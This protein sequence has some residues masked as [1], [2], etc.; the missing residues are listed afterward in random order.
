MK[1]KHF[2]NIS[3][4]VSFIFAILSCSKQPTSLL[5]HNWDT[6]IKRNF[7]GNSFWGNRLQ[8]WQMNNGRIECSN[9][10]DPWRTVHILTHEINNSRKSFQMEL[11][12]GLLHNEKPENDAFAGLLL[13]AGS[14]DLDYRGRCLIF[15]RPS[16]NGGVLAGING[17]GE[18]VILD[19]ENDLEIIAQESPPKSG[20]SIEKEKGYH[21]LVEAVSI[22]DYFQITAKE[23]NSGQQVSGKIPAENLS[24]NIGLVAHKGNLAQMGSFWFRDLKFG[25]E[26]IDHFPGRSLGPII[27]TQHT[28]SRQ[29]LKMAVQLM[30]IADQDPGELIFEYRTDEDNVW[31]T[32]SLFKI[33]RDGYVATIKIDRWNDTK[34]YEYRVVYN[35][36]GNNGKPEVSRYKGTIRKNPIHK[37]EFIIAAFTGNNNTSWQS[38]AFDRTR[39]FFPHEDLTDRVAMHQPDFLFYSGD[40]LYEGSPSYPDKSGGRTSMLDYLYK[41]YL[42]CWAHR[43]LTRNIPSVSIPDDHDVFHGNLWG[44]GG[45]IPASEPENGIYPEHYRGG[46]EGHW[47]QDQGGYKMGADFVNM[48][49]KTQTSNL[50]DPVDPGPVLNDIGVYFTD[51]NYGGVSMAVLED[52]KFKSAPSTILTEDEIINGFSQIPDYDAAK[53]DRKEASLLGERQLRFINDW[54]HDWEDT[55]IKV[56]LTQTIFANVSTYPDSFKTDAGTPRLQPLEQGVIPKDYSVAKDMDS[57][58]WPQTGRN[59]ALESLRKGYTFMI[60]GDQHLGSVV[61]HGIDDWEDAGISFC[62]PSV[63]NVWPRRWF[64]PN[65]GLNHQEGRPGYTGQYFDGF[66]NR[67]TVHAA[68]NPYISNVYPHELHDRAPGYGIIKIRKKEQKITVECWPRHVDPSQPNAEQYPDW[69]LTFD[70]QDNYGRKAIAWLPTI[71]TKGLENPPVIQVK[72]ETSGEIIY[73]IRAKSKTFDAKVFSPGKYTISLGEPGSENWKSIENIQSINE[74][75]SRSVSIDF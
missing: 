17:K 40:Q 50:P 53:S 1:R 54:V 59:K 62:V 32:S 12:F 7:L 24:G 56:S 4:L 73:T 5:I 58:G 37:D 63:A 74:K 43:E 22:D 8:D 31:T 25:G 41:W 38:D 19:M 2:L 14:L 30:P 71:E 36:T 15:N 60:A 21:I 51:I 45:K 35:Y 34:D 48:V 27:S 18:L 10:K 57:N 20:F 42:W 64:P 66:G 52:R 29:V 3:I 39:L 28:L 65:P 6:S 49:E 70:L 26:K 23:T 75:G 33:D 55:W 46:F 68:S 47:E 44:A 13:G 69:P 61:H 11:N 72:N 16:K 9:G 67:I